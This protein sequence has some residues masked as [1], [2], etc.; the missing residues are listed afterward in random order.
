[1]Y[2]T[3]SFFM[4][5]VVGKQNLQNNILRLS[6]GK[7]V[8]HLACFPERLLISSTPPAPFWLLARTLSV[9]PTIS[10][11]AGTVPGYHLLLNYINDVFGPVCKIPIIFTCRIPR[12]FT[13]SS[14]HRRGVRFLTHFKFLVAETFKWRFF[15]KTGSIR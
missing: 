5:Y 2:F 3:K 11:Q 1:M 9:F 6:H 7:Y 12:T 13:D 8:G 4:F 15:D 14:W 10:G